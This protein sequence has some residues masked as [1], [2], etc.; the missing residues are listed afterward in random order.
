MPFINY[1]FIHTL[2]IDESLTMTSEQ[3]L[4]EKQVRQNDFRRTLDMAN[5]I[6][7][8]NPLILSY[9]WYLWTCRDRQYSVPY[10]A[11]Q[12]TRRI[13]EDKSLPTKE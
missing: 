8:N 10:V 4:H 12:M 1:K 13:V 3:V 5:T 9:Y 6:I 2:A 11:E 7:E